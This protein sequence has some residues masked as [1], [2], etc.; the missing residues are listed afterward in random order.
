MIR[1][2]AGLLLE[3]GGSRCQD[4]QTIAVLQLGKISRSKTQHHFRRA[5]GKLN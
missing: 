2:A 5:W 4:D 1:D 3:S